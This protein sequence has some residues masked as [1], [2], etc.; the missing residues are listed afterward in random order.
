MRCSAIDSEDAINALNAL[1][2]LAVIDA[3]DLPIDQAAKIL[4]PIPGRWT[5]GFEV[6][7][8][9]DGIVL[10]MYYAHHPRKFQATPLAAARGHLQLTELLP[11]GNHIHIHGLQALWN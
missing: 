8:E 5:A 1:G 11:Y 7:G 9:V 10:T 2:A 6:Q 4:E 3:L